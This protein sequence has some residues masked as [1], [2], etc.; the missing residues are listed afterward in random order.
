MMKAGLRP[1][2]HVAILIKSVDI[3]SRVVW[4]ERARSCSK[5]VEGTKN[6]EV[7][8]VPL[9]DVAFDIAGRHVRDKC[10]NDFLFM[11]PNTGR[12]YTQW[13]L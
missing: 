6:K 9:N 5:Y 8:P 12:P 1:G 4:V 3:E 10:P 13:C 7:L 2:E 11:N